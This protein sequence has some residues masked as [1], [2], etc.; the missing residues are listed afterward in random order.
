M[1]WVLGHLSLGVLPS[2]GHMRP[3]GQGLLCRDPCV[4]P[5]EVWPFL[6]AELAEGC[7][8]PPP[9]RP[10]LFPKTAGW[11]R[12]PVQLWDWA[13]AAG[14]DVAEVWASWTRTDVLCGAVSAEA[15]ALAP[16]GQV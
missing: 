4:V 1:W 16:A 2:E 13:K 5:G 9:N 10:G 3:V 12:V 11:D 8:E 7:S 15:A 14:A 6:H